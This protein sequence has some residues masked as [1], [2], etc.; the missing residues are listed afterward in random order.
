MLSQWL[1]H[2][3]AVESS[4]PLSSPVHFWFFSLCDGKHKQG[5]WAAPE[6]SMLLTQY[7]AAEVVLRL[8]CE[9]TQLFLLESL[10]FRVL[11]LSAVSECMTL[12]HWSIG[13]SDSQWCLELAATAVLALHSSCLPIASALQSLLL[14]II[15]ILHLPFKCL[16]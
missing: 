16:C 6:P 14:A 8:C 2:R 12:Q 1:L 5:P 9:D 4:C 10:G 3:Q 7:L 15:W 13:A 11:G